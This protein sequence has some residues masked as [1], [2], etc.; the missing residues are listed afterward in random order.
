MTLGL[1]SYRSSATSA[2]RREGSP[3]L[4]VLLWAVLALPLGLAAPRPG[5]LFSEHAVLQRGKPVPIWGESAP[6]EAIAV[7]YREVSARTVADATGH[8][9]AVLP[10]MAAAGPATLTVRGTSTVAIHDVAVGDVWLV[11]GQS[12]LEWPLAK[13]VGAAEAIAA[14]NLPWLRHL[15]VPYRVAEVPTRDLGARW[16]VSS[17]A[18]AG[19]FSAV[20]FH[21]VR[22]LYRDDSVPVGLLNASRGGSVIEAWLGPPALAATPHTVLE[23]AQPAD[24]RPSG[25]YHGM[26]HPLLPAALRGVV[27]YQGESNVL[28]PAEYVGLLKSLIT[29]WRADFA[30]SELPF[31]VVQLPNY[32]D[33][34]F[35]W[36]QLRAAQAQ[37]VAEVARAHLAVTIDLGEARDKHPRDKA[38]VGRRLALLARRHVF[39]EAV[40]AESPRVRAAWR[41]E[42]AAVVEFETSPGGLVV[43]TAAAS[44]PTWEVAGEDGRFV[45]AEARVEG[46]RVVVAAAAVPQPR[47][48][49]Y[50]GHNNPVPRLFS[51]EGLP[52]APFQCAV[53]NRPEPLR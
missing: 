34:K 38:E 49:R 22:Q 28:R 39:G 9:R 2:R 26:L 3:S 10:A 31:L 5:A 50:L 47:T 6:G 1:D 16:V 21:F 12:N 4:L 53:T 13:T 36:W 46:D 11:A 45:S 52:V 29:G 25:L 40:V 15:K 30:D 44:G 19:D 27:W 24:A 18:T 41:R 14:A 42:G 35:S 8:W 23:G 37:A 17:P 7:E 32:A 20:A 43:R 51:P 48:V 33:G